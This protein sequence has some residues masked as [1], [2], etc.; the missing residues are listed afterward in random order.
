MK[1]FFLIV[2]IILFSISLLLILYLNIYINLCLK[3]NNE[4]VAYFNNFFK[5]T[6]VVINNKI[7]NDFSKIEINNRDYIG[8]IKIDKYELS[9]PVE[10]ECN[11]FFIDF[12]SACFYSDSQF[13]ILG[14]NLKNSFQNYKLYN[15]NDIITFINSLGDSFQFKIR[16][17]KRIYTLKDLINMNEDWLLIIKDYYN[18]VYVVLILEE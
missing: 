3:R 1:K 14:T 16:E 10:S 18:L 13:I 17:I 6:N 11:N 7:Q 4:I 9:L 5:N 2:G 8:F 12:K 15:I